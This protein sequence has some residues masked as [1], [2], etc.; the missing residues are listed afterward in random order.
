MPPGQ[1][2]AAAQDQDLSKE[3]RELAALKKQREEERTAQEGWQSARPE[4]DSSNINPNRKVIRKRVTKTY[5]DGRQTITFKFIVQHEEV[6]Q[7]M[8]RLQNAAGGGHSKKKS[9]NYD[10]GND[11]K[12][13]LPGHSMFEDDDDFEYSSKSRL[14]SNKRRGV[15]RRRGPAGGRATPRPRN[16]LQFGKLK[17]KTS[18]ED[19]K[20]KLKREEEELEVYQAT[21]RRKGTNNRRERGSIRDRRPHV[22]FAEK[23]ERIRATVEGRDGAGPFIKPVNRKLLPRYYEIISHPIDLQTMKEKISR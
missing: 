2:R 13:T 4:M 5:P 20:R 19:R 1:L 22:I 10:Q 14:L 6:G 15:T 9:I 17:T 7:V 23:L 12:V 3:A 11:D 8:A 21:S 16:N 18:K